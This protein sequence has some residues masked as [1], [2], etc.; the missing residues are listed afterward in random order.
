MKKLGLV[1]GMGPESTIPYYHDIVYGVQNKVGKNFFPNMTIESVN[2][3]DILKMCELKQYE[4]LINY[5]MVAINN[6]QSSGVDFIALSAN[7]PH[8]VFD[9]LKNRSNIP[10][11]SI[12][13]ATC[14]EAKRRNIYKVGLLGTIFTMK[15]DFFKKPFTK[16]HIEV[17]TPSDEEMDIVNQK[18]SQE[19]EFGIVK[20]ETLSAFLKIVQRMK[21]EDRIQAIVLGCTELPLLFKGVQTPVEC[22]DTMQIHIEILINMIIDD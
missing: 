21:A 8:I 15:G 19:L 1:G 12:I 6:L 14:N 4:A 16:N 22:L 3:F 11:V 10:L 20:E 17:I 9:E 5:L 13:D 2:V 7:T 18:I